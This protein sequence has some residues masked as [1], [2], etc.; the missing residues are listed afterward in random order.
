MSAD[1]V[2]LHEL[3]SGIAEPPPALAARRITGLRLDSRAIEPGEGFV[4]LAGQRHHGLAFAQQALQRGASCVIYETPAPAA[5]VTEAVGVPVPALRRHLGTLA[6]RVY[7]AP[8]RELLIVGVTG[9]NGKTSTVHLL[10]QALDGAGVGVATIGTLGSGRPGALVE[11]ERTTPDVFAVHAL[12]RRF[13]DGGVSHVAMEVSSHALDQGRIDGVR[14]AIAVFT[15]L[16]RDHLD[17]HGDMAAYG[18][19]KGR[20][21]GWPGLQTAVVNSDDAFGRALLRQVPGSVRRLRYGLSRHDGER[22]EFFAD[23]VRTD[24]DGLSFAMTTPQGTA[25]VATRLLGRFNVANLLA[26]AACLHALDWPLDRIVAA[27][28]KLESVPGR[29]N[30]YGGGDQPLVVVDY[31]HTPDAL[32]QA[33]ASLRAHTAQRLSCVF[34]CGGERDPGKR[35]PMGE[36]ASRVADRTVVTSDNPRGESPQDIIDA[37]VGGM[38]GDYVVI[39]DRAAAIA[40]AVGNAEPDDVILI[41]GKGHET[42]Q[43]IGGERIPFSDYDQAQAALAGRARAR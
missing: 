16:S 29:M 24:I 43:A 35:A 9:T 1:G 3:L 23:D 13:R 37:I 18:A 8:S 17:Y 4:A 32:E 27:M 22:P 31:A 30:R 5:D 7:A 25:D 6:E 42:F 12:L 11:G 15:N 34:G 21:F 20:L 14:F 2:V 36:T 26:V 41:A 40:H 28:A 10:A 33:L 39:P 19:A 38:G